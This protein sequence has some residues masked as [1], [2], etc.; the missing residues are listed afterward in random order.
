MQQTRRDFIKNTSLAAAAASVSAHGKPLASPLSVVGQ[1]DS[2]LKELCLLA[3]DAARTAGAPYADVRIVNVRDQLVKTRENRVT[4]LSDNET[5]GVGVRALMGGAW[6]FA[7]TQHVTR[8]ECQRV[9]SQAVAEAAANNRADLSPIEL[10]TVD[11]YPDSVWRSPIRMDPFRVPLDEKID[12]LLSANAAALAIRGT[13]FVDSSILIARQRTTFAST[14]GSILEQTVYRTAPEMTVTAVA[15][16]SSAVQSRY[17]SEVA[18]MGLGYEHVEQAN[19]AERAREWAEEAVERLSATPVEPGLYNLILDPSNLSL[20]IQQTI[21]R[22]TELDRVMGYELNRGGNSFLGPP[23]EMIG[24]LRY[25]P[26]FMNVLADR[27][28]EGALATVGWDDE[29]V[30]ADSWA[31]VQDGVFVDYQTTR[32]RAGR[33]SELTGITR[34]H[35]CSCAQSWDS[36]QLQRMPNISLMPG[37]DDYLLDDLIAATNR[38]ILIKGYGPYSVDQQH[39]GFQFGGQVAFEIRDGRLGPMLRDVAYRGN[40]LDFWASMDM[41]GGPRSYFIGGTMG[42]AKGQPGQRGAA[43]HGCPPARFRDLSVVNMAQ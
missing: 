10:A 13:R 31:I 43:S 16:D 41:L 2:S 6:G 1:S 38:G 11:A 27:T 29:G 9:A 20:T 34:S 32:E 5:F 42:H 18:P 7:A 12:L 26:E 23:E 14:E 22:P 25:G 24:K 3:L 30:P 15:P 4:T 28:Q 35:G 33:I 19:L 40:S 17:S 8:E 36:V 21:G 39:Y 37:E